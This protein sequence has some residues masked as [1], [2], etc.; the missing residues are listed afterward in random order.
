MAEPWS[1]EH[2]VDCPVPVSFAWQFWTTVDNWR[3][4]SDVESVELEGPFAAGS[5]GATVSRRSGRVEWR[6]AAV[7]GTSAVIEIPAGNAVGR[8]QWSFTDLGGRARITQRMSVAGEGAESLGA[9]IGPM[10]EANIPAGMQKLCEA[11]TAASTHVQRA[12]ED[13]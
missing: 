9:Q 5:R 2:S 6:I 7:E 11:M 10:F 12:A 13:V 1:F 8:F 4:D 3:L